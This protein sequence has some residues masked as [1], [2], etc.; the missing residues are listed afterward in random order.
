MFVVKH[1]LL[2]IN[3]K[4]RGVKYT[5]FSCS[6]IMQLLHR[7]AALF[8]CWWHHSRYKWNAMGSPA[9]SRNV[10]TGTRNLSFS[11]SPSLS[12]FLTH[13]PS[14]SPFLSSYPHPGMAPVGDI[15]QPGSEECPKLPAQSTALLS[16]RKLQCT[17]F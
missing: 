3:R 17:L 9:A 11:P 6:E 4:T 5:P 12:P 16:F 13:S 1:C 10:A 15:A 14:L 7:G 2:G 8:L